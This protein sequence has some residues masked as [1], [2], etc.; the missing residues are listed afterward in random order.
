MTKKKGFFSKFKKPL[1]K[2]SGDSED[3]FEEELDGEELEDE[4]DDEFEDASD[5]TGN[6]SLSLKMKI[7]TILR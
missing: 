3:E 2:K 1:S 4:L 5:R 6:I 7:L